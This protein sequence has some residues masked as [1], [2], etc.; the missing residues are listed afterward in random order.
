LGYGVKAGTYYTAFGL[1][2]AGI[3]SKALKTNYAENKYKYSGKELQNIEF[4]DGTGLEWDDFG[5][6]MYDGQ[7]GSW[8]AIDPSGEKYL[9]YSPYNYVL[10]NPLSIIDPDGMKVRELNGRTAEDVLADAW[11]QTPD[12]SSTSWTNMDFAIVN[13]DDYSKVEK[14]TQNLIQ[15]G[16]FEAALKYLTANIPSLNKWANWSDVSSTNGNIYGSAYALMTYE[17]QNIEGKS[18]ISLNAKALSLYDGSSKAYSIAG[19][20]FDLY[21]EFY[22]VNL[23][24]GRFNL[25][26]I[27]GKEKG[28]QNPQNEFLANY[29]ASLAELPCE[30]VMENYYGKRSVSTINYLLFYSQ[31]PA[32]Y[33]NLYMDKIKIL[34]NN[35]DKE[36]QTEA[37]E[38]IKKITGISVKL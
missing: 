12:N 34:L 19:L 31:D 23:N 27:G 33:V 7:I 35:V 15:I 25:K 29:Y 1:T 4:S 30:P 18:I 20:A 5:A 13:Q 11:N 17:D 2:M 36:H 10:G 28:S 26:S 37:I 21:H 14:Q 3:S 38:L 16:Q 22:H 9:N 8:R 6:R 24:A 32:K